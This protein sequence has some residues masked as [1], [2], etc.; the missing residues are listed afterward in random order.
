M[1]WTFYHRDSEVGQLIENGGGP[2]EPNFNFLFKN[3]TTRVS[4]DA[5]TP[6][7]KV[8]LIYPAGYLF[9]RVRGA[10]FETTTINGTEITTRKFS[11][12][13]SDRLMNVNLAGF[14]N[15]S[16]INWH[17]NEELNFNASVAFAEAG[18]KRSFRPIF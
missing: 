5:T 11:Q 2:V 4:V 7:Y 13:S 3:N 6:S 10:F 12:W 1:E 17:Q 16:L 14:S 15:K 8:N 18:K 9:Y